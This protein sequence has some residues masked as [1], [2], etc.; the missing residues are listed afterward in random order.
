MAQKMRP[1][2]TP[3]VIIPGYDSFL[4]D[5]SDDDTSGTNGVIIFGLQR[6]PRGRKTYRDSPV[7]KHDT[8]QDSRS[9]S[10]YSMNSTSFSDN[11]TLC[12]PRGSAESN[13]EPD[14]RSP[15]M[16]LTPS[17][18][19]S[20]ETTPEQT[21]DSE[22]TLCEY[23]AATCLELKRYG[24]VGLPPFSL[25]D[26]ERWSAV[27]SAN[28][29]FLDKSYD[30]TVTGSTPSR[31]DSLSPSDRSID[32]ILLASES[33]E[34][35]QDSKSPSS[36]QSSGE[37][38][39]S[40]TQEQVG[41][42]QR[43]QA[44]S[45][46]RR[47]GFFIADAQR[48]LGM[49]NEQDAQD[50]LIPTV[51]EEAGREHRDE[52]EMKYRSLS[53]GKWL[54]SNLADA[55]LAYVPTRQSSLKHSA[56]TSR[57]NHP[58]LILRTDAALMGDVHILR[59]GMSPSAAAPS[60]D[61]ARTRGTRSTQDRPKPNNSPINTRS[62]ALE[63]SLHNAVYNGDLD[64]AQQLLRMGINSDLVHSDQGILAA[65]AIWGHAIVGKIMSKH[66]LD[67]SRGSCATCSMK[68]TDFSRD[69]NI[70]LA[71]LKHGLEPN[72]RG[73][74]CGS[75]LNT[76][77]WMGRLDLVELL[78]D[79]GADI[80][81]TAGKYRTALCSAAAE[82]GY[83]GNLEVVKMLV[84]L[85]VDVFA[86]SPYG[87]ARTLAEK[88]REFWRGKLAERSLPA[89]STKIRIAD[90]GYMAEFLEDTEKAIRHHAFGR[91]SDAKKERKG[92]W[93]PLIR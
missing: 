71:L 91:A 25:V 65:A 76:A 10:R 15:L 59:D 9:S 28:L 45:D 75:P 56:P 36:S 37:P 40:L 35:P 60:M 47:L 32:A 2:V 39:E 57:N 86:S 92:F 11:A 16:D 42:E 29:P 31:H 38:H 77:A 26:G 58:R 5:D 69:I 49:S 7:S 20:Y 1:E 72:A 61:I 14:K 41:R 23:E 79:H 83:A 3:I 44:D 6:S 18:R 43:P 19:S 70:V 90:C 21:E 22:I 55:P 27:L 84:R 54:T 12:A 24:T 13:K 30:P 33:C 17:I 8:S 51:Q 63:R 80:S 73:G 34:C 87:N 68:Y 93:A 53:P 4:L 52:F 82:A 74:L 81:Q 48:E 88:R 85:G 67:R 64:K 62:D 89:A 50:S 66:A 78:L 46:A